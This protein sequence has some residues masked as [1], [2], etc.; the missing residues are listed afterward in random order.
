MLAHNTVDAIDRHIAD[1]QHN[2]QVVNLTDAALNRRYQ[3]LEAVKQAALLIVNECSIA[4]TDT[5]S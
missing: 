4:N 3:A 5:L 1:I 2:M